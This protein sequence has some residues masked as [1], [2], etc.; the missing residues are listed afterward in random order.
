M[1]ETGCLQ[2]K[3]PTFLTSAL[4]RSEWSTSYYG[5]PILYSHITRKT[6]CE[7]EDRT[8]NISA[9]NTTLDVCWVYHHFTHWTFMNPIRRRRKC[10]PCDHYSQDLLP[11]P[12]PEWSH[13]HYIPHRSAL[14]SSQSHAASW[15]STPDV[16]Y[17][18]ALVYAQWLSV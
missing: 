1:N 18:G 3:L 10:V 5:C 15:G 9:R 17:P 7:A 8:Q 12:V 2:I 4:D 16:F 13:K 14:Q 6:E 11:R